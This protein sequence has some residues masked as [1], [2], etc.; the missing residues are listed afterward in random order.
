MSSAAAPAPSLA[1]I[2]PVKDFLFFYLSATVVLLA[3]FASSVLHVRGDIILA[4]VAV[5]SNGPH[6]VSTWT[7]VY[8]DPH[9]WQSRK[10]TTVVI[11]I[12]IFV[13]VL[14]LNWKLAEYGPRILNSAILYWATWHFVAQN[15][16]I[17]RIYQRKSG[18]SLEATALKLEKP[19]LLVSVLF[20]VLHRLYTG[21]RTLFG[22]EVYYAKVPYAAILALLAPIAVLLGFILVT[23]IRERNQPWAKGAWLR[24]AFIGCSFMGFFV[25]FILITE[26]STSAF[27]AAACWHGF[28]YLG[29]MR[30]YNRNTWKGGVNERAKIISWLSQ[31]G[32]SRGFLYWAMLMAL[33]GAVYVVVFALSL[34]TSWSFFT[35][36]GVIWV[37]LTLSHYWVDGVIWKLRK[38]ELAQR[39][40]IQTAA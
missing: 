4:T 3:W 13:F 37:S 17:L 21:P 20:C 15:W 6:L 19:L 10:L 5:A 25:P 39:V 2:S 35:W 32:W 23:R 31:P 26:D 36:A 1:I 27:A 29:M 8:F 38:P 34:V 14:L 40:G 18:E 11:P 12:V 22:V 28:Q 24:L 30:H 9:E 33:A 16:G 7:R